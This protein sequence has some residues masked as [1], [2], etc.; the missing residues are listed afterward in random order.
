MFMPQVGWSGVGFIKEVRELKTREGKI[1]AYGVKLEVMGGTYELTTTD[2]A[3]SEKCGSGAVMK[4]SGGFEQYQGSL[5]L[6]LENAE[7]F[8]P[9]KSSDASAGRKAATVGGA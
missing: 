8:D 5:K 2:K 7:A 3:L 4:V 1:W 6:R 9:S